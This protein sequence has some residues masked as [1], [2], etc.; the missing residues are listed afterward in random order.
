MKETYKETLERCQLCANSIGMSFHD[1]GCQPG[2]ECSLSR[3]E[4][5][6]RERFGLPSLGIFHCNEKECPWLSGICDHRG[7]SEN[8][9]KLGIRIKR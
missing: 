1:Y 9:A 4:N 7:K 6:Q 5:I 2:E 8:L 3:A